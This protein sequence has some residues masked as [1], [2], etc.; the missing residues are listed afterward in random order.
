MA[1]LS[2]MQMMKEMVSCTKD[3]IYFLENYGKV[4]DPVNGIIPF[5]LYE[6]QKVCI[7]SFQQKRFN[8]TLKSRQTG[9]STITAGYI[10]WLI[11]FHSAKEV[12]VVA[13]KK[14][15]A[16]GFIRKVKLIIRNSPNWMVPKI[17]I[18]NQGSITLSN[19]SRVEAEATTSNAARSESLS[20]LVIDEAAAIETGKVN[21]LWAA[22]YPTLSLGG[23]A[24]IISTPKG[25][26]N[27]Y[28]KQWVAAESGESDF[29]PLRIHWTQHPKY[30]KDVIWKC[31]GCNHTQNESSV[32]SPVCNV[33]GESS[34]KPESPW[35]IE[36]CRQLGDPRLIAQEMDMDFLGSG[37]NVILEEYIKKTEN[38]VRPPESI[39]GFDNNLWT[40]EE[41]NE[42]DKY[43]ISADVAR[44]DGSDYSACHV[45]KLSN[46][47]QVAE[48]RGKLP[49]DMYAK[50]LYE[51][52]IKYN[53]ALLAIEANSIGYAT[54]LKVQ[55]LEYPNIFYS[56]RGQFNAR[57]RRKLEKA[58]MNRETMV[59]GFQTTTSTRPLA[60]TQLEEGVRTGKFVIHSTRL[61]SELRTLIWNN[62]K[63]E[64]M[65][66][67]NDDLSMAAAIGL[68]II[69]TTL[70]DMVATRESII[71]SLTNYGNQTTLAKDELKELGSVFMNDRKRNNPWEM[72]VGTTGI[73][74]DISWLV[75][76]K[77]KG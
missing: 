38:N 6:Y 69:D 62:G 75:G 51:L 67:Y 48:Y 58:M 43:L 74:E 19:G 46:L 59:P 65:A 18:D 41:P 37:D 25:V 42:T 22:A 57:D 33:C 47:E 16:Q 63:P 13:D 5:R 72:S 76:K 39:G 15:N 53:K 61:V 73:K 9:L 21:D 12:V 4:R 49:P 34:L 30:G 17:T 10:A 45:V 2:K 35:Y 31:M 56:M 36:Q 71:A 54:C 7:R 11:T 32:Y 60:I 3:P 8:I 20:L 55:E 64:A 50:F 14:K 29:N 27:F 70:N 52:G 66:G 77:K 40:W 1:R 28:H 26:G 23:N 44:G 68:L 24:V